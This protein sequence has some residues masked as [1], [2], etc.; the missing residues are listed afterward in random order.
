M[1]AVGCVARAWALVREHRRALA[2]LNLAYFGAV[3]AGMVVAALFP[4]I[5]TELLRS[6]RESVTSGPLAIAGDAYQSGNVPLAIGVTFGVNLL[7]GSLAFVTLPSMVVPFLGI[8]CGAYRAVLWGLLFSPGH[9][10]M[11]AAMIPH[12]LTLVVEGEAYVLAMLAVWLHGRAF[13]F[14]ASVGVEGRRRG[15]LAGLRQTAT[16]YVL[17]ALV[18]LGAAIYEAIEVIYIVR[19]VRP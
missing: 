6:S 4:N 8:G 14:P 17:V 19:R 1:S 15:Y 3:L 9:P 7:V 12:F 2:A 16:I 18:L 13:L 11:G 5:Q 10:D